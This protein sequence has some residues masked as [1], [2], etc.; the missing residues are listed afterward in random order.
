MGG[1]I[2]ILE[3][4]KFLMK[5]RECLTGSLP[6][7]LIGVG[8]MAV[9]LSSQTWGSATASLVLD[10]HHSSNDDLQLFCG[11]V[12]DQFPTVPSSVLYAPGML[13]Q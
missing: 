9:E 2:P 7:S 3:N 4:Q 13:D 12:Q 10:R 11:L 8:K 1:L 6:L 5:E